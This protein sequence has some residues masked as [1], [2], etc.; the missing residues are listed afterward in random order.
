VVVFFANW[1]SH[2]PPG[3]FHQFWG[4][5]RAALALAGRVFFADKLEDAWRYD[6]LFRETFADDP[7]VPV[8]PDVCRTAGPSEWFK[9]FWNPGELRSTLGAMGWDVEIHTAG[10]FFW[11]EALRRDRRRSSSVAGPRAQSR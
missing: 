8:V 10:P 4:T 6:E 11:A 2:V 5:V 1:L 3:R 7:S 9:V